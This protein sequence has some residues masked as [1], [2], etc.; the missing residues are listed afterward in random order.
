MDDFMK[1]FK[2]LSMKEQVGI[3][4]GLAFLIGGLLPFKSYDVFIGT[5]NFKLTWWTI[6][7]I[8]W[9]GAIAAAVFIFLK[10]PFFASLGFA[11]SALAVVWALVST[12]GGYGE[13]GISG[14]ISIGAF[15][16]IAA[17]AVGVWA[18]IDAL[19]AKIKESSASKPSS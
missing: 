7:W 14:G 4:A 11:A 19:I 6:G 17:A 12:P 10:Q 18:T 2:A 15:I 9:V 1:K 3:Y 8:G 16:C 5:A 13:V